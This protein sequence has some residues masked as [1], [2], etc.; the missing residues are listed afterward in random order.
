MDLSGQATTLVSDAGL[1]DFAVARAYYA[2]FDVAEAFRR[3]AGLS[4]ELWRHCVPGPAP[5]SIILALGLPLVA[6]SFAHLY[7]IAYGR[8]IVVC[9]TLAPGTPVH[10]R[11]LSCASGVLNQTTQHGHHDSSR[12]GAV[13]ASSGRLGYAAPLD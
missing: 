8:K 5:A 6:H 4:C 9:C 10:V 2:M 3:G 13:E 11:G 7:C 12:K 1:Y